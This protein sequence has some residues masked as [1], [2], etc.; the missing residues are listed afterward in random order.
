MN[1]C[2]SW[3]DAIPPEVMDGTVDHTL[4]YPGDRGLQWVAQSQDD[5]VDYALAWPTGPEPL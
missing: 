3:P 2:A 1:T 5:L 4:P